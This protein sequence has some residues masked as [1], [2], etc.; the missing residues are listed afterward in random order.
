M[1]G[2]VGCIL[3]LAALLVCYLGG[4]VMKVDLDGA[5][6]KKGVTSGFGLKMLL[7]GFCCV[8]GPYKL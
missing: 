3:Y 8:S 4:S 5:I 1:V 7:E 2:K 6:N